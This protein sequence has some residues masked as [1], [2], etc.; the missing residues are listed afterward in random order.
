MK[1]IYEP[2]GRAFEYSPLAVNL[3]TG[4]VHKCAYC[5]APR[6]SHKKRVDFHRTAALRKGIL[7]KLAGDCEELEIAGDRREI[8]LCF[9][10]DPYPPREFEQRSTREA[11]KLMLKYHLPVQILTKAPHR[12]IRD[13]DIIK[14]GDMKLGT[15]L[16]SLDPQFTAQWEKGAPST[17]SRIESIQRAKDEGISTW[18]SL[19]PVFKPEDALDIIRECWRYVDFWR[20]GKINHNPWYEDQADWIQFRKDLK[21]LFYELDKDKSYYLKKSLTDLS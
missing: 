17:R 7:A 13:F 18:V 5:F 21:Y 12:A 3:Y 20:I 11:L 14:Q 6:I 8:L 16:V 19:E 4:C 10:C 15:T 9:M 2:K 1:T